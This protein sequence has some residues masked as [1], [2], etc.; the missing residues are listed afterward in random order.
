M[1]EFSFCVSLLPDN[2]T[3]V[4][5]KSIHKFALIYSRYVH[6][7]P[8]ATCGLGQ[9]ILRPSPSSMTCQQLFPASKS[10]LDSG[11]HTA[12][13]KNQTTDVLLTLSQLKPG[14]W[15]G[16]VQCTASHAHHILSIKL[17]PV[18]IPCFMHLCQLGK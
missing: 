18:S 14:A 7:K 11:A 9:L 13:S 8:A 16:A 12:L 4:F 17:K 3:P 5:E 1:L 15:E 6:Y 2:Q 10:R